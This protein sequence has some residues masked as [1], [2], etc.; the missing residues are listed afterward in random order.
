[1]ISDGRSCSVPLAKRTCTSC[2]C[3]T[4]HSQLGTAQVRNFYNA[5]YDLGVVTNLYDK[6]RARAYSDKIASIIGPRQPERVFEVGCGSGLVLAELAET[7]PSCH[8]GGIEP[9][10]ALANLRSEGRIEIRQ[11]F[12]EAMTSD[13]RGYDL[14]Y[15][16]NVIEHAAEPVA[17]LQAMARLLAPGGNI[18][19]ICPQ[20]HRPNTE[21][22]FLDHIHSFTSLAMDHIAARAGLKCIVQDLEPENLGPFQVFVFSRTPSNSD[23]SFDECLSP[24]AIHTLHAARTDY[25]KHWAKLDRKL[26]ARIEGCKTL[27]AFGA[28]EAAQLL[29]TYAPRCWA[30]INQVIVDEMD[31]ARDVSK[32]VI[33][34]DTFSPATVDATLLAVRPASQDILSSR[35]VKDC[36]STIRWDD[37]VAE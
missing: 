18:I 19:V 6:H 15:S 29:R 16:I 37:I 27:A 3:V 28:G 32:P 26:L 4:L 34:Y 11:G 14:I 22:L 2:G 30:R 23:S 1:M 10:P 12:A 33:S 17:F 13:G 21:L 24:D 7:W 20:S 8:L 31:K 5:D 36:H 9:S 35:L 25:F